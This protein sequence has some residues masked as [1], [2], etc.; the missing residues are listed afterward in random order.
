MPSRVPCPDALPKP[1]WLYKKIPCTDLTRVFANMRAIFEELGL[2]T[3]CEGARCPN[4]MDCFAEGTATFMI[5]GEICTRNCRFCAVKKGKP[6]PPDPE[7]PWRVAEAVRRLGLAH[8]V[9]T[10]VTRDDLPDGGAFQFAQTVRAIRSL[11]PRTT[12]EVLVPDFKGDERAL[13]EVLEAEPDVLN[14]NVET[15]PRLYSTVRPQANYERSLHLLARAHKIKPSLITKSGLMVG[16]GESEEEVLKVL[17]DLRAAGCSIVTIGQYLR[18]SL[19]HLP[20]ARYIP[21]DEFE[22]F[23]QIAFEMGFQFVASAP[24]VRSSYRAAEALQAVRGNHGG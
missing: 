9:I 6:K 14:H 4:Q 12:V 16:L 24:F 17:E 5:L 19:H 10:S 3:V 7:E 18:P 21:P 2:Y 15:V 11:N 13:Q 23:K 8:A 1:P 22:R 20:V